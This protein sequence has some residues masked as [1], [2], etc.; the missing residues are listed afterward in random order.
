MLS[1]TSCTILRVKYDEELLSTQTEQVSQENPVNPFYVDITIV[2]VD[3]GGGGFLCYE[4][5]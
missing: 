3:P 5:A 1:T 2:T 4:K